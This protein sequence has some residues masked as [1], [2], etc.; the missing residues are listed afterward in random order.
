VLLL[1]VLLRTGYVTG[2][3]TVIMLLNW[4]LFIT[5]LMCFHFQSVPSI[6]VT[7]LAYVV[8]MGGYF[9]SLKYDKNM[10]ART[11]P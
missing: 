4:L 6:Y 3:D 5:L 7:I 10:T 9:N 1:L 8:L 11:N 2:L